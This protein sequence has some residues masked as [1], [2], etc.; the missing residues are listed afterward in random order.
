M[1]FYALA[2]IIFALIGLALGIYQVINA[3]NQFNKPDCETKTI[4]NGKPTSFLMNGLFIIITA[5][6]IIL[7]EYSHVLE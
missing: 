2:A 5:I 7:S 3:S 1:N 6:L 4:D